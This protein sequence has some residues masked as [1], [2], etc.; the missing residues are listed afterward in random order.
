MA[1]FKVGDIVRGLPNNG[2][3]ITNGEMTKA[4]VVCVTGGDIGIEVL[5]H[6]EED[7]IG[8]VFDVFATTEDFEVIEHAEEKET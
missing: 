6:F 3:G 2:Y 7:Y 1:D 8:R 5:E 4:V